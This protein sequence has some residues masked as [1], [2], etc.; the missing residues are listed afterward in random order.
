MTRRLL[1]ALALASLAVASSASGTS[2]PQVVDAKGDNIGMRAGTDIQSVLFEK[3]MKGKKVT[4]VII[5]LTLDAPADRTPG[6]LYR[7]F[8]TQN[9]CGG[10][11]L[12][13]A[14]TLAL[15]EQNQV[16]MNCGEPDPTTG[17]NI[18]IINITPD[19]VG[20]KLVWT[21]G[22]NEVPDEMK[23][24]VMSDLQ[25]FVTPADPVTGIINTADEVPGA[26]IDTAAG[27]KTFSY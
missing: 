23:S 4:A 1:A 22:L 24:G 13:S 16:L 12:S 18:T 19:S 2:A 27:T 3:K 20:N 8:G 21:L 25:A 5:T 6:L 14:A 11:Q 17:E 7:V 26:A 10:F 15:V 9:K